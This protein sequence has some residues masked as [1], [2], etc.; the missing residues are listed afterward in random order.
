MNAGILKLAG[1]MSNNPRGG[2]KFSKSTKLLK[3]EGGRK[4]IVIARKRCD[5]KVFRLIEEEQ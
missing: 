4:L 3:F 2:G 5:E 1:R